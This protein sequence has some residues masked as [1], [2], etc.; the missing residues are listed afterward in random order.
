VARD[1]RR[2]PHRHHTHRFS[3]AIVLTDI[4]LIDIV[5]VV[6]RNFLLFLTL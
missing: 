3:L 1:V 5:P 2:L 4:L 6:S